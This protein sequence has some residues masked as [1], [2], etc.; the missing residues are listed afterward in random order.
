MRARARALTALKLDAVRLRGPGTDLLVGLPPTARWEPPTHVNARGIE[1]VWNLPSEEVY[2]VPN[3]E[4][5]DGYIRLT[6]PAVVG[7]RLAT[8]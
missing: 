5:A 3:R 4:R 1:R 8:T 2:T 6:S 7:G